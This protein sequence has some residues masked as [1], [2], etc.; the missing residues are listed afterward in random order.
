MIFQTGEYKALIR[1]YIHNRIVNEGEAV[2]ISA[3]FL[4]KN[5]KFKASWL[6]L[7]E[8]DKKAKPTAKTKAQKEAEEIEGLRAKLEAMQIEVAEGATL[9]ELKEQLD[10]AEKIGVNDL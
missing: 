3:E 6:E 9:K 5:P 4:K 8:A 2:H 10:T 1:G 7:V